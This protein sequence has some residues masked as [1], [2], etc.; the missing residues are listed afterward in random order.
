MNFFDKNF[1]Q[2]IVSGL[3][4]LLFTAWLGKGSKPKQTT[5]KGWKVTV[6]V[7]WLLMLGGFYEFAVSAP[8]GGFN[9]PL[10]GMGFSFFFIGLILWGLGKFMVWWHR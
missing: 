7:G 3:A 4:I 6:I 9:N 10:T 5:P 2:S 8:N 1:W